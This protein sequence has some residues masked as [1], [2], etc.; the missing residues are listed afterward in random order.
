MT[1]K[2]ELEEVTKIFH[3]GFTILDAYGLLNQLNDV[4]Q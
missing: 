1:K 2:N 4:S 3:W